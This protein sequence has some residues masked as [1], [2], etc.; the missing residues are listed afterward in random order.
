MSPIRQQTNP[1]IVKL[2]REHDSLD[3]AQQQARQALQRQILFLMNTIKLH[4]LE[5][6][7]TQRMHF[8]ARPRMPAQLQFGN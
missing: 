7:R 8:A 4:E 2:L 5:E 6:E 1:Q 3:Y